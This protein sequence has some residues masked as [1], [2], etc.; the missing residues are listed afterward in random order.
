V[1]YISHPQEGYKQ[2]VVCFY[3]GQVDWRGLAA[4]CEDAL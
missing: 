1:K 3:K 4:S 2:F